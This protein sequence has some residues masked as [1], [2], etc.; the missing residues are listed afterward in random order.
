MQRF[1][2]FVNREPIRLNFI[3]HASS[4]YLKIE[5]RTY[6]IKKDKRIQIMYHNC[7]RKIYLPIKDTRTNKLACSTDD[8]TLKS[9]CSILFTDR[10]RN[11]NA[12]SQES[13]E[14]IVDDDDDDG[15]D[16]I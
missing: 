9:Y 3:L 14:V 1:Q 8:I 6:G 5:T 15:E 2:S 4:I 12:E 10:A 11:I 7:H 13:K 16:D